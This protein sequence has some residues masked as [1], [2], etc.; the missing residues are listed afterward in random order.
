M[1][2]TH[3]LSRTYRSG[4]IEVN[5]LRGV[6]LTV[7]RGDFVAIMGASGS[8]KS[9]LMAI[10]GCLD[11]P[12]GGQYLFEGVNVSHLDEPALAVLRSE[13][14]GFVFQSFNLLPRTTAIENVELPLIYAAAQSSGAERAARAQASLKLLGLEERQKNTPG[15]L[16]GGQQQRV[17]IARALINTPAVLLADEPTGNLD[18]RTAHEIMDVLVN[19]NRERN[20][21]IILV[22]H[23]PD[24][25]SYAH[26]VVTMRD[27]LIVS[28]ERKQTASN[29]AQSESIAGVAGSSLTIPAKGP[30]L[31]A[32][33][34][35]VAFGR[36]I[37]TA[38]MQAIIRNKMRSAL[39][40]LGVFIGVAA[41]I[42][43]VA[44]GQGANEAVRK[45]IESLGTNLLVVVPGATTT[46]GVRG[47]FGSASTLTV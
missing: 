12:T 40:T 24:I 20:L 44:V 23:E 8:G 13:R 45:Q 27:G 3:S 35:S 32:T 28:D 47:G 15:Q 9:T 19:L 6:D 14:L 46:S 18:T 4:D 16:S 42:A 2:V 26:R 31:P 11:R 29:P 38:A 43:M 37:L 41:L 1:I 25:A 21:T 5:A 30:E 17:A 10:L 36:M 34:G 7:E 33:A 39:T 22:T